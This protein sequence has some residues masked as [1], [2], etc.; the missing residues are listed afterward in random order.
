[1]SMNRYTD[2]EEIL[3]VAYEIIKNA[4]N[5]I[6]MN[7]RFFAP[8]VAAIR[9]EPRVNTACI[10]CGGEVCFYDPALVIR[11]FRREP[12]SIIRSYLHVL[13][14]F[15]FR[16]N[17]DYASK[18]TELWDLA[19]DIATENVIMELGLYQTTLKDDP[20]RAVK[21]K[22]LKDRAGGLHAQALYRLLLVEEPSERETEDLIR[23]FKRDDH[24]LWAPTESLEVSLE[25]WK[26][27]SERIKADLKSFS[28]GHTDSESLRAALE[29][30]TKERIDYT[31][32]LRRFMVSEESI[33]V[34]DEEFDYIYY[35]YGLSTYGNMP[36]IEPLEYADASKIKEFVIAIDTSS[37]CKGELVEAFLRRTVSIIS[38]AENFFNQYNVHIIQCDSEVRSDTVV[39]NNEEL[40]AFIASAKLTGFG[41][42]DFRPVFAYVDD[43]RQNGVFCNLRGIIYFTDGY[44]VYPASMPEYDTAFVFL[45]DDSQAPEVP[46]W[47]IRIVLDED[48]VSK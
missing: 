18:R 29:D 14:H 40:E 26:K 15:I 24:Y 7:L 39:H 42:T 46:D 22:T 8:A 23:L 13:L 17:Y 38:D 35:T 3:S 1:M 12:N 45:K 48:Q 11:K 30:A 37:S 4:E 2:R 10:A 16:H 31:D 19:C 36:L 28:K 32:F 27:I 5:G 20:E 44:G 6:I 25:Q 34:N 21:L 43:L 47:A 33:R 41:S 9:W